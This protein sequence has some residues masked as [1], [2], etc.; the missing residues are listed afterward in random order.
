MIDRDFADGQAV[1]AEHRHHV[2]LHLVE[3]R[4]E[5]HVLASN[6]L[7]RAAGVANAV[8]REELPRAVR[9]LEALGVQAWTNSAVTAI[10]PE[11]MAVGHWA[12][13]SRLVSPPDDNIRNSG[14]SMPT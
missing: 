1:A 8:V 4:E 5:P 6:Q 12:A 13:V 2:A 14:Q 3:R 7:E 9:D 10:G 11:G